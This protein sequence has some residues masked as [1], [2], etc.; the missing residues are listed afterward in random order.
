VLK[1]IAHGEDPPSVG[2]RQRHADGYWVP[3]EATLA[4]IRNDETGE[5]VEVQCASRDVTER[6]RLEEELRRL[7]VEDTL[8]GLPNRRGLAER[9]ETELAMSR[10][11]SGGALLLIDLDEFKQVNDTLGHSAGDRVLC[12]VADLLRGRMRE[13]DHIARLGGDEFAAVLPR[14]DG[15]RA[16]AAADGILEA[17]REDAELRRLFGHRVTAS[18]GIALMTDDPALSAETLL[19]KADQAMYDAKHAG[20]N[21]SSVS[22]PEDAGTRA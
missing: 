15:P 17:L 11:Y 6:Q 1:E 20:R 16:K 22:Q 9:L 10:R 14:V 2:L 12:R 18:V 19:M 5:V 13:S 8:T 21:R 4:V 7:A 3:T